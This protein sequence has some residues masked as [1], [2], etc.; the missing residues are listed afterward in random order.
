[1]GIEKPFRLSFRQP[2]P[3]GVEY[4]HRAHPLVAAIADHVAERGL[5]EDLPTL[6]ARCGTVF[7]DGVTTRTTLYLLRLRSQLTVEALAGGKVSQRRALLSEECLTVAVPDGGEL[8]MLDET[9]A[10]ALM[11]AEPS[12]NMAEAQRTEQIEFA[13][14][15]LAEL[16]E[17]FTA[18]AEDRAAALLADHTRVRAAAGGRSETLGVRYRVKPA[19][20]V[21]VIGVYVLLPTPRAL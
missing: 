19:L 21:D 10:L 7:T 9:Q 8:A 12:R 16:D 20:P 18:I 17:T 14:G 5:A 11:A 6:A 13:L 4:V 1:V 2:A 3:A 15:D